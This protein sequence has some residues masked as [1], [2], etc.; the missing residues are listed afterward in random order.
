MLRIV[1]LDYDPKTFTSKFS[2]TSETIASTTPRCVTIRSC[3]I[4]MMSDLPGCS[5]PQASLELPWSFLCNLMCP[6][7]TQHHLLTKGH[8]AIA[9]SIR[10]IVHH[11]KS[12][13]TNSSE[14]RHLMRVPRLQ[15]TLLSSCLVPT[16]ISHQRST[17]VYN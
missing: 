17:H 10:P 8:G 1:T 2:S 16:R 4:C 14:P 5:S 13:K 15:T 7:P 9:T 6:L 11:S 3:W 12:A